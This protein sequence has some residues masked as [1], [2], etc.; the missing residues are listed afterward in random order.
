MGVCTRSDVFDVLSTTQLC[1]GLDW[2]L[3]R[4]PFLTS[5]SRRERDNTIVICF[6]GSDP[7][8]ITD[9]VVSILRSSNV[10]K[11][12]VA[13]IGR[14]TYISEENQRFCIVKSGL[15]AEEIKDIF[16]TASLGICSASS[17]SIEASSRQLPILV[18]YYVDNQKEIY[19]SLVSA[20]IAYPLGDLNN[21]S[22]TVLEDGLNKH[23]STITIKPI[24]A[25]NI[26]ARYIDLFK[27]L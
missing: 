17:V 15:S 8:S 6:G 20:G 21:I 4:A 13:I 3:L 19:N 22:S 26:K 27:K 1:L 11:Q 9:K 10:N 7:L 16:D 12:I 18:G 23:S 25:P 14:S 5:P 2:A 24:F